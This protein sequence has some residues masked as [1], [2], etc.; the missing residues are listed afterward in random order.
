MR[1]G[2]A[3]RIPSNC[4]GFQAEGSLLTNVVMRSWRDT[5][6]IL[7]SDLAEWLRPA[8]ISALGPLNIQEQLSLVNL[9]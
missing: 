9:L 1:L 5:S 7:E 3:R 6:V 4:F 8:P 2:R